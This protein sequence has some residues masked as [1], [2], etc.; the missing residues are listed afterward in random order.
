ML[1][2]LEKMKDDGFVWRIAGEGPD[3]DRARRLV[4]ECG[5][6]DRVIFLGKLVN[7]YPYFKKSDI[8]LVPSYNEAAPMV[9]GEAE[10]FGTPVFSTNTLSAAEM[11]NDG[12]GWICENT[13]SA[14]AEN[15]KDVIRDFKKGKNKC[16]K[17]DNRRAKAEFDLLMRN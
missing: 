15:L 2:I 1:P 9:F 17:L 13:D 3:A 4:A 7:P 11:I 8:V 14:I 16:R 12:S 5:L 6:E 10:V